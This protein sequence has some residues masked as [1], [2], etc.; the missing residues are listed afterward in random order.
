[1]FQKIASAEVSTKSA[2]IEFQLVEGNRR[3]L[4]GSL[5][6]S[7]AAMRHP[8]VRIR[9]V[10]TWVGR[11]LGIDLLPA[12]AVFRDGF[13]VMTHPLPF[14]AQHIEKLIES[15]RALDTSEVRGLRHASTE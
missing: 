7:S 9:F 6:L 5:A 14:P 4:E 10:P 2:G 3:S 15:L 13:L 8:D 1:M 11:Q 12:I